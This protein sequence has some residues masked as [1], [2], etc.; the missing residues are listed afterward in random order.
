MSQPLA[1][2]F[3]YLCLSTS[4]LGK[5]TVIGS[6]LHF[7]EVSALQ[8]GGLATLSSLLTPISV[9]SSFFIK[10]T[11]VLSFSFVLL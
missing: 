9:G 11:I 2:P 5:A 1:Y 6:T 10:L 7:T 4:V 3:T 8:G